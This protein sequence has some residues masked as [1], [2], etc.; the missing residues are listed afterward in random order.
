MERLSLTKKGTIRKRILILVLLIVVFVFSLQQL[1]IDLVKVMSRL[2]NADSVLVRMMVVDVTLIPKIIQELFVSVSLAFVALMFGTFIALLLSLMAAENT[3]FNPYLSQ[4][5]KGFITLIRAVPTLVWV[6]MVVASI[7]FGNTGG[8]IG[9]MIPTIG[10]L[11]KSFTNSIE[12]EGNDL[13]EAMQSAALPWVI[14]MTKGILVQVFPQ[15][16]G[17]I[18]MR[19]EANIAESIS[20]GIVGVSGIGLLIAKA[21][22]TYQYEMLTTTIL[23]IFSVMFCVEIGTNRLRHYLTKR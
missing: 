14:I 22:S 1:N 21:V 8:V 13:M 17:W 23:V 10:F 18:S 4:F 5:I 2:S 20:L 9:L 3:S 15:L 19:L 6:L 16:I 11:T 7:G 12:E